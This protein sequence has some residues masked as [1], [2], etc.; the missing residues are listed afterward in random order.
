MGGVNTRLINAPRD[1]KK[2][3]S[4]EEQKKTNL[5]GPRLVD[6]DIPSLNL[7]GIFNDT[8]QKISSLIVALKQG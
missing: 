3:L 4:M 8:R 7:S 2:T 5:K 1:I 6:I